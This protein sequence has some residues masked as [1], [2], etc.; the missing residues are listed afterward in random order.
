VLPLCDRPD[1]LM[2]RA[3]LAMAGKAKECPCCSFWRGALLGFFAGGVAVALFV[4][5][6]PKV[7]HG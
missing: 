7:L 3:F 4:R 2:A 6:F 1:R 5:F